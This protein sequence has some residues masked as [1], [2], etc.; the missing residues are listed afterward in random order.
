MSKKN[1]KVT[2]REI[3]EASGVSY[4]T[5]SVVLNGKTNG[6]IRVS[7]KTRQKIQDTALELGYIPNQ[8]ARTLKGQRKDLIAVFTYEKVFPV[9]VNN[10]FYPFFAGIEEEAEKLGF[11]LLILN[12]R[13]GREE[14]MLDT[15]SRIFS[16]DGAIMLGIDRDD[17]VIRYLLQH[18]FPLVF[19]GRRNLDREETNWVTLDYRMGIS[20]ILGHLSN[21]GFDQILYISR[22]GK[23]WEPEEDRERFVKE[24]AAKYGFTNVLSCT[25]DSRHPLLPGVDS[26]RTCLIFDHLATANLFKEEL[27]ST[28]AGSPLEYAV[29]EDDWSGEFQDWTRLSDERVELGRETVRLLVDILE[30]K[31]TPPVQKTIPVTAVIGG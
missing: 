3:A 17:E 8:A 30:Q 18:N 29:F 9:N 1:S 5:V 15:V 12:K 22:E 31:Q 24:E 4:A 14:L 16:A 6:S 2:I 10:E 19:T 26:S 11:D 7:D 23:K 25:A 27:N 20:D 21:R 13:P 28:S